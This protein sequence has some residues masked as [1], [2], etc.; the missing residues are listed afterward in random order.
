MNTGQIKGEARSLLIKGNLF[1]SIIVML[2]PTIITL[3]ILMLKDY[4][5]NK[6]AEN[7]YTNSLM[8]K[9]MSYF[10]L[11]QALFIILT[12]ITNTLYYGGIRWYYNLE[13]DKTGKLSQIFYLFIKPKLILKYLLTSL[14]IFLIGGVLSSPFIF[15][16]YFS[17]ILGENT[18]PVLSIIGIIYFLASIYIYLGLFIFIYLVATKD[19]KSMLNCLKESWK[20][21]S[22]NRIFIIK[23]FI[24]FI[25]WFISCVFIIPILFV[26]PYFN[27]SLALTAKKIINRDTK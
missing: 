6:I 24:S 13:K 20:K 17:S 21:M 16:E 7:E 15:L 22:G 4:T 1:K 2:L 14:F 8:S 26:I 19:N 25:I 11:T 5:I 23:L 18:I 9:D 27:T 3:I 12:I 10:I